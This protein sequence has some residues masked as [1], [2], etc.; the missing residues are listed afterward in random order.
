MFV[1][2]LVGKLVLRL[3]N[4]QL[5]ASCWSTAC[6]LGLHGLSGDASFTARANLSAS[7]SEARRRRKF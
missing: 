2:V 4:T 5:N 3:L 1:A 7:E 6:V